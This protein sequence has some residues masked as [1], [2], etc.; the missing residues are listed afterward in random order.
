M[1]TPP[2]SVTD[3]DTSS[4]YGSAV[5]R[6]DDVIAAAMDLLRESGPDALTSVNVAKRLGVTQSA[7][8]RHIRDMDELTTLAT[9]G[10]VGELSAVMIQAV[11]SPD[12]TWGDGTH[13]ANFANRIVEMMDA[14]PRALAEIDRWRY[15]DGPLGEGIRAMLE[16]GAHLIAGELEKAWRTD[17]GLDT[18]FDELTTAVQL[19]HARLEIDDVIAVTRP[20]FGD[21][22]TQRQLV[23][24]TLALRLFAGWC[25]YVLEINTRLGVRIPELGEPT[26]SSP[27]YALT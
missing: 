3:D 20:P 6:R 1:V 15:D 17:F 25:G 16:V 5:A 12:T 8:Y 22:L 2:R 19:A 14:H 7:I 21:V 27:E 4:R 26:L 24:R 10:I 23:A 11:T 9:H 18:E 13:I